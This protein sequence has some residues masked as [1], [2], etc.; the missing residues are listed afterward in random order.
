MGDEFDTLPTECLSFSDCSQKYASV[1]E[2]G[3]CIGK[4]YKNE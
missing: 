4:I 3:I 2:S 1:R